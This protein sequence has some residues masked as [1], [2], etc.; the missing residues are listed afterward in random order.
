MRGAVCTLLFVYNIVLIVR[1]L[2]SWFPRPISGPLRSVWDV[3]YGVTDPV[4]RPLRGML[5]P[6]RAGAVAL[7]LSPII[8]FIIIS[9]L[10]GAICRS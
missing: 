1:V 4:L 3:L 2:S 10:I 6:L 8:A 5:P 7:D 9:V